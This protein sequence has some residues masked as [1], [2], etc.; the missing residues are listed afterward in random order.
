MTARLIMTAALFATSVCSSLAG[1][2]ESKAARTERLTAVVSRI[3]ATGKSGYTDAKFP[4]VR[5]EID[6]ISSVQDL[7]SLALILYGVLS[8]EM[9]DESYDFAFEMAMFTC[10]RKL[11]E[12]PGEDASRA[13]EDLRLIIGRDGGPALE[14]REAIEKQTRISKE[15]HP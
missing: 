14:L 6:P 2:Q 5:R 4:L 3:H 10:V 12:I 8:P 11:A 13:L 9:G 1:E 15:A 7:R